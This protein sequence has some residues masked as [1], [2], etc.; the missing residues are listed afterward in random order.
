MTP[1]TRMHTV[2]TQH[3]FAVL[4]GP[5]TL[6]G[7]LE[8]IRCIAIADEAYAMSR[9]P[10]CSRANIDCCGHGPDQDDLTFHVEITSPD[11]CNVDHAAVVEP[12]F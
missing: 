8:C 4:V 1:M 2:C 11:F 10:C 9:R 12:P 6:L 7:E 3:R 5:G